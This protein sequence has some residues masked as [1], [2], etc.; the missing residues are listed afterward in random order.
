MRIGHCGTGGTG[1]TTL[2]KALAEVLNLDFRPS[3]VREVFAEFGWTEANQR[4]A[5][6][7]ENWRLQR[8]IFERKIFQDQRFGK[9]VIMDRTP[10]D[11]LAYCLF[12]C[13]EALDEQLLRDLEAQAAEEVQKYDL[14]I[15]HPIPSWKPK[16]DGMRENS[17]AY[18]TI[19]DKLIVGYLLDFRCAFVV[20]PDGPTKDQRDCIYEYVEMLRRENDPMS[21]GQMGVPVLQMIDKKKLN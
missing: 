15:Y 10:I 9:D 7:E 4:K 3:V 21:I 12:R 13:E 16:D 17:F 8:E 18:R 5:T 14:I 6:P 11:H 1:K 2:A 20:P 19:I